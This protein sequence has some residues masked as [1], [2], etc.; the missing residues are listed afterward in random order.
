MAGKTRPPERIYW[1]R[2]TVPPGK[3]GN[4]PYYGIRR[5]YHDQTQAELAAKKYRNQMG[6]TVDVIPSN[7]ITWTKEI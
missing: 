5:T 1:L 7:P 4:I 3:R 2:V 6:L